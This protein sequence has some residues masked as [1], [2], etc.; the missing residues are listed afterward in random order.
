MG[1][2]LHR[3]DPS[4]F[5]AE[6]LKVG[7]S[8]ASGCGLF[9]RAS[10][11]PP[12]QAK[13]KPIPPLKG[14]GGSRVKCSKLFAQEMGKRIQVHVS[15]LLVAGMTVGMVF[16]A[17]A[18]V[19]S[20]G[21]QRVPLVD[22]K[23]RQ[24]A[25]LD[26]F[27][28]AYV[29]SCSGGRLQISN[30]QLNFGL[31]IVYPHWLGQ[32]NPDGSILADEDGVRRFD[33]AKVQGNSAVAKAKGSLRIFPNGQGGVNV[34]YGLELPESIMTPQIGLQAEIPTLAIAGGALIVDGQ[35]IPIPRVSQKEASCISVGA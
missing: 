24:D 8:P 12:A 30:P 32:A 20:G 11:V 19:G 13:R 16:H 17:L 23:N 18:S 35:C 7:R 1:K 29:A 25:S 14:G 27:A 15:R 2:R 10:P 9:R 26:S 34:V 28:N 21:L 22:F 31:R 4:V 6:T 3:E 33:F 5:K